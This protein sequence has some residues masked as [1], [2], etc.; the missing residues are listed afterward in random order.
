ML[1]RLGSYGRRKKPQSSHHFAVFLFS[2]FV[3]SYTEQ[4]IFPSSPRQCRSVLTCLLS[5]SPDRPEARRNCSN[6]C[7]QCGH[8][9]IFLKSNVVGGSHQMLLLS[10]S[11]RAIDIIISM[12][13][14]TPLPPCDVLESQNNNESHSA[15]ALYITST[16]TH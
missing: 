7:F 2:L 10:S 4:Y 6:L 9:S 5:S 3:T 15:H 16:Q 11:H 14:S 1:S 8:S 12:I 13:E